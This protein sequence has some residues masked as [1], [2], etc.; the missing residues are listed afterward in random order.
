MEQNTPSLEH[1]VER[2]TQNAQRN[3]THHRGKHKDTEHELDTIIGC[4][5][6]A[7]VTTACGVKA[8]SVATVQDKPEVVFQELFQS[9][10]PRILVEYSETETHIPL[11][12]CIEASVDA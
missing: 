2:I 1:T 4:H 3:K 12:K 10:W 11:H 9:R 6:D 7:C 5:S 8:S